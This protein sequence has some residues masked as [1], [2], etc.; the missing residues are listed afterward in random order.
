MGNEAR[1]LVIL[2]GIVT[3]A[4]FGWM[5]PRLSGRQIIRLV[6]P[7]NSL[8]LPQQCS[9]LNLVNQDCWLRRAVNIAATDA[10]GR[11][12]SARA[13]DAYYRGIG[14]I[15]GPETM[16]VKD[17]FDSFKTRNGF[18]PGVAGDVQAIYF[19]EG[20]LRLGREMH[21]RQNGP[22]VACYV[23]N[24][25]EPPFVAGTANPKWPDAQDALTRTIAGAS[26]SG[27][28][29]ATV[30]M[31]Y[32]PT[33]A[34][35]YVTVREKDGATANRDE[36][37]YCF[38]VGTISTPGGIPGVDVDTGIDIEPG[39]IVTFF[40]AGA[41]WSGVCL[42]GDS[43][44]NGH[45]NPGPLYPLPT[46]PGYGLIGRVGNGGY[47]NIGMSRAVPFNGA[48]GG[49][50]A[51]GGRLFLRTNDD[52]PGDGYGSFSVSV[53]VNRQNVKFYIYNSNQQLL[54]TAALD[55]EGD[56]P[57]PQMCM[58]CHGGSYNFQNN[59]VTGAS[60]LPFDLT[61]FIFSSNPAFT[62]PAQ[63]E[64]FRELNALV[65]LA[66]PNPGSAVAEMIDW[67]YIQ[68]NANIPASVNIA[69]T[70]ARDTGVS[71]VPG[72][73]GNT[74]R[75]TLYQSFVRPYCRT[76]HVA[77][78]PGRELNT[79]TQL[80]AFPA[81]FLNT[82][83]CGTAEM[84]HAQ[85]PYLKLKQELFDDVTANELRA[86]GVTCVTKTTTPTLTHQD[87]ELEFSNL[88]ARFPEFT[89]CRR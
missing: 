20:D 13:T 83:L 79:Y 34:L 74:G 85:V 73:S 5:A 53:A 69:G 27:Q 30:A 17:T 78:R 45:A 7:D 63:E 26:G 15:T 23:S 64:K 25:G 42:T 12:R 3:I 88:C 9:N 39:D 56:K 68:T 38:G 54:S 8:Q 33:P 4:V 6:R 21:C 43:D 61:N 22:R 46:A 67:M 40:A 50:P 59:R 10:D 58:T 81:G 77:A 19:N 65:K 66:N 11:A 29:F 71:T 28:P 16:P 84:P 51:R 32:S 70:A 75:V 86:L 37:S 76:C 82:I 44:A 62:R 72:W 35:K 18:A 80:Q 24:Y 52:K 55:Q 14:A 1:R 48:S 47:F 57:V 89:P 2:F 49:Q 60:F 87:A 31:E 41:I 36:K